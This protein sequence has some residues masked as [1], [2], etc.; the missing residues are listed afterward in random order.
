MLRGATMF[1]AELDDICVCALFPRP[2]PRSEGRTCSQ[3]VLFPSGVRTVSR[4]LACLLLAGGHGWAEQLGA[5]FEPCPAPVGAAAP[6]G[7]CS[8]QPASACLVPALPWG[9]AVLLSHGVANVLGQAELGAVSS[10]WWEQRAPGGSVLL[11][12]RSSPG[13]WSWGSMGSSC[14]GGLCTW[15]GLRWEPFYKP[16]YQ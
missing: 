8:G 6:G 11:V 15:G 12:A 4:L 1:R 3:G 10:S 16:L 2:S 5:A 7:S 13:T 14:R 9:E